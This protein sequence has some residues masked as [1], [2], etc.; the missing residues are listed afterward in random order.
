MTRFPRKGDFLK[1]EKTF[2]MNLGDLGYGNVHLDIPQGALVEILAIDMYPPH[3]NGFIDLVP[4]GFLVAITDPK[5]FPK[6]IIV[7]FHYEIHGNFVTIVPG[8][9][10]KTVETLYGS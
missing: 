3:N 5:I 7:R 8:D 2:T 9:N 1:F 6:P 4:Y 10:P